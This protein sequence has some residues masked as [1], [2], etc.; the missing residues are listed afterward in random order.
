[1][2]SDACA[3]LARRAQRIRDQRAGREVPG[4]ADEVR[5]Q[6]EQI[7]ALSA[8]LAAAWKAAERDPGESRPAL[9]LIRGGA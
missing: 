9:R 8:G 2:A 1:M 3:E 4:L 6:A 7:A 5:A